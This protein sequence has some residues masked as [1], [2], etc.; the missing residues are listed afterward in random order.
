MFRIPIFHLV[1]P[2]GIIS[3]EKN[4]FRIHSLNLDSMFKAAVSVSVGTTRITGF[5]FAFVY[6]RI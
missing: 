2:A 6:V 1:R 4:V 5:F 3:V